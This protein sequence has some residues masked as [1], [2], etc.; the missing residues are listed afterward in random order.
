M[1]NSEMTKSALLKLGASRLMFFPQS[2]VVV[3][4]VHQFNLVVASTT[5]DVVLVKGSDSGIV[6]KFKLALSCGYL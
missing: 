5:D 1:N 6:D 2:E 3:H 4:I